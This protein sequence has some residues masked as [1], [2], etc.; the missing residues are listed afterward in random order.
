MDIIFR[1]FL[2]ILYWVSGRAYKK[3]PFKSNILLIGEPYHIDYVRVLYA[4]YVML[5]TDAYA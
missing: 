2:L 5:D 4:W 3:T 1:Y